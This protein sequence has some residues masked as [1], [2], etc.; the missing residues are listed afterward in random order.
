MTTLTAFFE[1]GS[2]ESKGSAHEK[3]ATVRAAATAPG[4]CCGAKVKKKGAASDLVRAEDDY[5]VEMNAWIEK[6][7]QEK[8]SYICWS[9]HFHSK[10]GLDSRTEFI[11]ELNP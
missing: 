8:E 1:D 10:I 4:S 2:Q 11:C 5:L 3:L 6:C 7:K 9:F